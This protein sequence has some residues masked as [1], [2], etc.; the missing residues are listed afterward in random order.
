MQ[1]GEQVAVLDGEVV[2]EEVRR[3]PVERVAVSVEPV[4][5]GEAPYDEAIEQLS[6]FQS[7]HTPGMFGSMASVRCNLVMS[8]TLHAPDDRQIH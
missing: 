8:D 5:G 2:Q 3:G 1:E 6:V 7:M 4:R